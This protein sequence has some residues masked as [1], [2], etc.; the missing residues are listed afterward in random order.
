M[1]LQK[2]SLY[3]SLAVAMLTGCSSL[4][5][6]TSQGSA[7]SAYQDFERELDQRPEQVDYEHHLFDGWMEMFKNADTEEELSELQGYAS[8]PRWL[9]KVHSH[10]EKSSGADRCL[11]VNGL[12]F[13]H[14]AGTLAV[15]Y[16]SQAGGLRASEIHYQYWDDSS[17]IPQEAKCP[18]EFELALPSS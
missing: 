3:I 10:Y 1:Q 17:E 8:Y 7:W 13:D 9:T 16:V 15:R 11:S 4:S 14:S 12:T 5:G 18:E 6:E 2:T